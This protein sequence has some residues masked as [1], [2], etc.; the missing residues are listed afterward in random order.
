MGVDHFW[1]IKRLSSNDT[2]LSGGHQSGIY[3][4]NDVAFTIF[5]SLNDRIAKNPDLRLEACIESHNRP[6]HE[7][8]AIYYNN[9]FSVGCGKRRNECRITRW[10]IS[11]PNTTLQM[12]ATTGALALFAF[13]RGDIDTSK[14]PSLKVWICRDA[15]EEEYLENIVGHVYPSEYLFD[16][17]ER[18]LGGVPP[19]PESTSSSRQISLP[20]EWK[21]TFPSG[22]D[23]VE[24][25]C[26]HDTSLHKCDPDTRLLKRRD[27]EFKMF[28]MIED[29]HLLSKISNGFA[30]VEDFIQLANSVSNRRKSRGGRSLELHIEKIF[31]EQGIRSFATQAKTEGNKKPDFLFPSEAAYHNPNYPADKLRMLAIKTT[32]KDR[33][34]QILNEANRIKQCH[35]ITLQEGVSENQFKEMEAEGVILVVPKKI[36]EKFPQTVRNKLLTLEDFIEEIKALYQLD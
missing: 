31:R 14:H 2:G 4:P 17:S 11:D 28:R 30:S 12:P 26:T 24:F 21:T 16:T 32:C 13:E 25:V 19:L 22:T 36:Q 8:R 18:M 20:D 9:R 29:A 3:I 10:K 33:W 23:I 7:V 5:P 35:L 27:L 6:V 34:R 1:Y 15:S